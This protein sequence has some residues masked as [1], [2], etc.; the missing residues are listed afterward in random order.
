MELLR[1]LLVVFTCYSDNLVINTVLSLMAVDSYFI[2]A[3]QN[4]IQLPT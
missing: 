3:K 1:K 4:N 2:I